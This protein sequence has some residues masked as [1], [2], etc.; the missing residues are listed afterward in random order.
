MPKKISFESSMQQLEEILTEM[1]QG[2][3]SLDESIAQY[4]KAAKLIADCNKQLEN[5]KVKIEEIEQTLPAKEI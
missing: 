5:A 4:A 2:N 3:L 1:Q